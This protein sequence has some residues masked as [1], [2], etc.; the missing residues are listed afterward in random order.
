[1]ESH[2][3][4]VILDT[5]SA[6]FNGDYGTLIC[7]SV[8]AY[9]GPIQTFSIR[10]LGNDQKVARDL[11]ARLEEADCWVTFYGKGHD[12]PLINTRLLK[13]GVEPVNPRPH[14]DMFFQLK[15]KLRLARKSQAHFASWLDLPEKKMSVSP[16]TWASLG[17]NFDKNMKI[18][19]T[20]CESDVTTLEQIYDKC[21]H[22]IRD[23]TR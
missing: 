21:K 11:K 18:I 12:I 10:A 20:R 2:K 3:S 4:L 7:G 19:M 15:S 6:G 1:M 22:L 8:K 13:W 14:V 9:D 5:E 17:V 16:D 23:V